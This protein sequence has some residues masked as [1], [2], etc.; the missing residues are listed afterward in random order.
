VR[1]EGRKRFPIGL[2]TAL[3]ARVADF[4]AAFVLVRNPQIVSAARTQGLAH[5][6]DLVRGGLTEAA[7]AAR[8]RSGVW[9]R[10]L[11]RVVA[12]TASR[13]LTREQRRLAALL[14]L[15]PCALLTHHDAAD[16]WG[17]RPVAAY[18]VHLGVERR[19]MPRP[20]PGYV[21][22]RL[23]SVA[24]DRTTRAGYP[25]T[26][27]DRTVVDLHD[28]L[29][30]RTDR[31]ALVAHV[32]QTRRTTAARLHEAAERVPKLHHRDELLRTVDLAAAGAHSIG[33]MDAYRWL[34]ESGFPAPERQFP[35]LVA[36]RLRYLD[37]ADPVLRIAYETDGLHHGEL[38]QRDADNERDVELAAEGW[39]TVRL[40]T[41]RLRRDPERL[42][43]A[44]ARLR[45]LR[46]GMA[47]AG[48]LVPA[49]RADV[50]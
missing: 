40:T 23:D 16:V 8:L 6:H 48:L 29:P 25:V 15:P 42:R 13:A 30:N 46:Q 19:H 38:A 43:A 1:G 37:A 5:V 32:F 18:D 34:V 28:I 7:L 39:E 26:G 22:H 35:T 14:W 49:R 41:F 12:L 3:S 31:R 9:W 47:D 27:L 20:R 50:A 2:S 36:G 24:S 4:A 33:E 45:D 21:V 10:P 44:I 17:I 11:P